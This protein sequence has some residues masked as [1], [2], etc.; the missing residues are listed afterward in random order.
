M[1]TYR[2]QS[3]A[4]TSTSL[5][6]G[7]TPDLTQRQGTCNVRRTHR[8]PQHGEIVL[9]DSKTSCQLARFNALTVLSLM[10]M[11]DYVNS[12]GYRTMRHAEI[13]GNPVPGTRARTDFAG[14]SSGFAHPVAPMLLRRPWPAQPLASRLPHRTL[15]S[16]PPLH[17]TVTP[18][19]S[20]V[21][22]QS[23]LADLARHKTV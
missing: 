16:E 6:A 12:P 17:V 15:S 21:A 9:H 3:A 5:C 18:S 22:V 14:W 19:V 20:T 13:P 23:T 8:G 10:C 11:H 4:I 2:I 7:A 1:S